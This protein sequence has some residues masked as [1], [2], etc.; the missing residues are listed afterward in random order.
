MTVSS[1]ILACALLLATPALAQAPAASTQVDQLSQPSA[2]TPAQIAPPVARDTG[3]LLQPPREAPG[4]GVG[5]VGATD[6][7]AAGQPSQVA[8]PSTAVGIGAPAAR[9]P[10]GRLPQLSN[11]DA[12]PRAQA[13]PPWLRDACDDIAAGRAAPREGLDC[14]AVLEEQAANAPRPSAEETLL[15]PELERGQRQDAVRAEQAGLPNA[16]RIARQLAT[17]DVQNAPIAQAVGSGFTAPP[18]APPPAPTVTVN[19]PFG[20]GVIVN[21]GRGG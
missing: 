1:P 20:A 18:P 19:T 2:R 13:V 7:G 15:R 9:R 21:P 4:R 17:G 10:G 3:R 14:S 11:R 12:N 5:Q 16:D 6:A 8:A